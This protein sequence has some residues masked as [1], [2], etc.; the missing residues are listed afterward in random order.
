MGNAV[1]CGRVRSAIA[2]GG[3]G[4]SL[5]H[6]A[7]LLTPVQFTFASVLQS[8]DGCFGETAMVASHPWWCMLAG[9]HSGGGE[10]LPRGLLCGGSSGIADRVFVGEI[11]IGLDDT[12]AVPPVDGISPS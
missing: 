2:F 3:G 4:S 12:D 10:A 5:P 6:G 1:R 9:G 8:C 7:V 11:L